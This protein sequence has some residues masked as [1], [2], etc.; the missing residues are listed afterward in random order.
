VHSDW[1]ESRGGFK[2]RITKGDVTLEVVLQAADGGGDGT[3]PESSGK[4]VKAD[5]IRG[6]PDVEHEPA[7]KDEAVLK[8]TVETIQQFCEKLIDDKTGG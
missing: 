2:T 4:A 7:Y 6:F 5:S 8:F 3:V 1:W